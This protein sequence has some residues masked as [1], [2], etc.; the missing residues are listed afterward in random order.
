MTKHANIHTA[1]PVDPK[2]YAYTTPEIERHDGWVKIGYT[3][4]DV[5]TRIKQQTHTADVGWRLEWDDRAVFDQTGKTFTDKDFH[6]YLRKKGV[7]QEDGK[8]NEWFHITGIESLGMFYDFKSG[9]LGNLPEPVSE[10]I[11]DYLQILFVKLPKPIPFG[12]LLRKEQEEAVCRTI[13][14]RNSH[15]HGEFLWN[16]KPRFGKTLAAY[17]ACMKANADNVLIVTNR[18]SIANSWYEDYRTF[19]GVESG[20]LFVS[21]TADLKG[22]SGVCS[23]TQYDAIHK[24]GR[25]GGG[26]WKCIE[27]VSLQDL[28][29]SKYFSATGTVDKLHDIA[30]TYWDMLIVD[31]AHEGVDTVKTDIAFDRIRRGFTLHLSGTPFKALADRKF[32]EDA[33][34]NWT[35]ADEQKAKRDWDASS[36]EEN[37]YG[38]LPQL[39]M[40]TYKMSD[41]VRDKAKQGIEINGETEEYAFDLNEFFSTNDKGRFTHEA[42]VDRFLDAL[43]SQYKFPFSTPEL[44]DELKHTFW[45]LNR[46]ESAKALAKKLEN[47]KVFKDYHIVLAVGNETI[48]GERKAYN[49]VSKAIGEYP[50]TITLSVGQLTTG[51]TI[52]QW[53]GVLMLSNIASP[54]LYMQA[55]FR[56]QNPC[57]FHD[58]ASYKRKENAYV[59]DFDPARSLVIFERFANGLMANASSNGDDIGT[60]K[61]HVKELLNFLPVIGEDENGELTELDAEQ[62]LTFPRSI[63]SDEVVRSGFISNFLFQNISQVFNAPQ[64]VQDIFKNMKPDK[65]T[66]KTMP[67][68]NALDAD[69]PLDENGDVSIPDDVIRIGKEKAFGDKIYAVSETVDDAMSDIDITGSPHGVEQAVKKLKANRKKAAHEGIAEQINEVG[70]TDGYDMRKSTRRMLESTLNDSIDRIIDEKCADYLI[71]ANN[72]DDDNADMVESR[73]DEFARRLDDAINDFINGEARTESIKAVETAKCEQAKASAEDS[74]RA[75]LRG[76]ARTIPSF[77]MAYGDENTT[78]D[79]FDRIIPGDVFKEL[80][81]IT[82][83]DFR[84]LRDGGSRTDA[85]GNVQTFAGHVFDPVVFNDSVAKFIKLKKELSNYFDENSLKDIF[86]CIP[87]QRNNQIFTPKKTVKDMVDRLEK[88]NPGCFDSPDSTFIDLYMKSGLYIAEIVKRL[89]RSDRM[90]QLYPNKSDRLNHIF[91]KQVYG[92]APTKIIYRIAVNFILGFDGGVTTIRKHNFRQVDALEC[93]K[94]GTLQAK[95]DELYGME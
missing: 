94:N 15:P 9:K 3:E 61:R 5:E 73:F 43:S 18:P 26:N 20:Y 76:F 83:E 32:S 6:A 25:N 85:E 13:A 89:Y 90:K 10:D 37:P 74:V 69:L 78:L 91:E 88:E 58:G 14:Y 28:K 64:M 49:A 59:F 92:L 35:Y 8:R 41:I 63:R 29:G 77:L 56:A 79:T 55:A 1:K 27:F 2:I 4:Q 23:R 75:Q 17:D 48:D 57:L 21:E 50:R 30:A 45:L 40:F 52:P 82:I 11:P 19:L 68:R 80:T 47:H 93:A 22:K 38:T 46:V 60:R 62:V 66:S 86:D 84:F 71:N 81:G 42:Q 67:I 31:E 87:P 16:A 51:V 95:L 7:P 65:T 34:Y 33:I 72:S 44:R 54:A 70:K 39:N 24:K 36:E 53:T 12:N